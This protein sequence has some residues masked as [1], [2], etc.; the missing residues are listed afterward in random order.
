[1]HKERKKF[2][3]ALKA[4]GIARDVPNVSETGGEFLR[5]LV[6][7]KKPKKILE[8]GMANGYSTIWMAD[9]AEPY[10]GTIVAYDIS[11][12][13]VAEARINFSACGLDNIEIRN[14]NPLREPVPD[15]EMY[16]MI[17]IDGQKKYYHD[18]F[19]LVKKHLN[20]GGFAI[21]DD[22]IKFPDKTEEFYKVMEADTEYEKVMLPIDA[23]DGVMLIQKKIK[24]K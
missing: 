14:T 12:N 7:M 15:G 17:H 5:F 11:S 4:E 23:D 16:D 18:F 8:I 24:N 13:T 3:K 22:V 10:G 19:T 9:S 2:L 21:F 1:M 6:G 20:P